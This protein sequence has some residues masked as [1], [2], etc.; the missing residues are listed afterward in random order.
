MSSNKEINLTQANINVEYTIKKID[1]NDL[2]LKNFLFTLGCY[3]GQK[4]TLISVLSENYIISVKHS[5]YS[6]DSDLAASIII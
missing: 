5:R 1:T 3:S 2:E 4:L 6:I